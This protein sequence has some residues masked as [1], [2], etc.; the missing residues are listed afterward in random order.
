MTTVFVPDLREKIVFLARS[1]LVHEITGQQG[2]SIAAFCRAVRQRDGAPLN[3]NTLRSSWNRVETEGKLSSD[4]EAAIAEACGFSPEWPEWRTGSR[5]AFVARLEGVFANPASRDAA[6]ESYEARRA[7]ESNRRPLRPARPNKFPPRDDLLAA[8][9]IGTN[10]PGPDEP[11]PLQ[12]ELVCRTAPFGPFQLAV[13]RGKLTLHLEKAVAGPIDERLGGTEP[14]RPSPHLT[15]FAAGTAV[16]PIWIIEAEPGPIGVLLLRDGIC[17]LRDVD[18]GATASMRFQVYVKDLEPGDDLASPA[19]ARTHDRFESHSFA[20]AT[21]DMPGAAARNAIIKRLIALD[22]LDGDDWI[23]L[24]RD[25][26]TFAIA[27]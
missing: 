18:D 12:L 2:S 20:L 26:L 3:E 17:S 4:Y 22:L 24:A 8:L 6:R 10:Q 19:A 13:R 1:R 27:E 25:D 7:R 14:H 9:A 15:V 11:W 16:Q 5:D 21:P 23:E